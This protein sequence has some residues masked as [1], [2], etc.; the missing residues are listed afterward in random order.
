MGELLKKIIAIVAV[1]LVVVGFIAYQSM[2]QTIKVGF[3][4]ELST[5]T[6][7]LSIESRDAFLYAVSEQNAKGGINGKE[8][9]PYLY[10]DKN[11]NNYKAMLHEQLQKDGIQLVIGFNV[12]AMVETVEY[13]MANGDYLIISPT[14]ST[15]YMTG[16][17]DR[18]IKI[19][20][21]NN[22]QV[23]VLYQVVEKHDIKNLAIVYSEPNQLYAKPIAEQ[24]SKH[25]VQD[26]RAVAAMIGVAELDP[27]AVAAEV[28]ASK[29]DGVVIILDSYNVAQ[30]LQ[31]LRLAG[32]KGQVMTTPWASTG[33]LLTNSGQYSEG[34]YT[35]AVEVR[36]P[37]ESRRQVLERHIV[38]TTN[39]SLNFSHMRSYNACNMLFEALKKSDSVKPQ[40]VKAAIIDIGTFKGV[41]TSVTIDALGDNANNYELEQVRDGKFEKVR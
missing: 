37:D 13:L 10:D 11:D 40:N 18:F 34:V 35:V 23:G 14:I 8:I 5:N 24:M 21:T 26:G 36:E 4:G 15:D 27:D 16:K 25:L 31:R 1:A 2:T 9:V 20:P 12:S 32:F 19:S 22:K 38:E 39:T 29:A 6:S 41:E 3:V 7:R 28:I 30:L 33:E 17:D